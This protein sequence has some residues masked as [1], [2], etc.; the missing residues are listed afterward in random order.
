[1]SKIGNFTKKVAF[2]KKILYLP[3]SFKKVNMYKKSVKIILSWF[4]NTVSCRKFFLVKAT[5]L[6][7]KLRAEFPQ[8]VSLRVF[9]SLWQQHSCLKVFYH[10]DQP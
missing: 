9:S 6:A 7:E 4:R 5:F 8:F 1:M 10:V 3:T 2:T